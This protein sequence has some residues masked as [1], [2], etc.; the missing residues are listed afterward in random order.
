MSSRPEN[1]RLNLDILDFEL[2]SEDIAEID[3]LMETG[4][5]IVNSEIVPTAPIWD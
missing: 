3:L 5:R 1:L 4:Y 2:T